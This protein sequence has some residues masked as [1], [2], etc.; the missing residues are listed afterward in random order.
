MARPYSRDLRE[1]AI[2][3][4]EAG[5]SCRAVARRFGLSVS[6]VVKWMQRFRASG[7]VEAKPMGGR[8]PYAL[9]PHRVFVLQRLAEKPDLT[10]SALEAELSARGIEISRYAVW[11][12][13]QHEKQSFKKKPARQRAGSARRR[14]AARPLEASPRKARP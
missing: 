7:S 10:I 2:A 9:A 12:F 5:Q 14:Q 1:K 4:V 3:A 8:R 11:H 6:S 13:L